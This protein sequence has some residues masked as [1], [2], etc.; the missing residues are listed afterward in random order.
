MSS[1]NTIWVVLGVLGGLIFV[2]LLFAKYILPCLIKWYKRRGSDKSDPERILIPSENVDENHDQS[3]SAD[4]NL[5][6]TPANRGPPSF[7]PGST[8]FNPG[9]ATSNPGPTT[10]NPEP[11]TSNPANM[12]LHLNADDQVNDLDKGNNE[13][14]SVLEKYD[15]TLRET[16]V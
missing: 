13:E 1:S 8:L 4:S 9:P 11:T 3:D 6:P 2:G 7:N 12:R 15:E 5:A 14:V 10:S 16:E